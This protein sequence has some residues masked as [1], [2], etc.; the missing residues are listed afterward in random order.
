MYGETT[1]NLAFNTGGFSAATQEIIVLGNPSAGKM[2]DNFTSCI[3]VLGPLKTLYTLSR[4]LG[5][6]TFEKGYR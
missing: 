3:Y 2:L 1:C 4:Y 5:S 6:S